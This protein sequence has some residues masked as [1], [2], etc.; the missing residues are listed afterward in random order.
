VPSNSPA[1]AAGI[2]QDDTLTRIGSEHIASPDAV[3]AALGRHR[4]GERVT[5]EYID[6]TGT[7]K[8]ANVVLGENPHVN[9]IAVEGAG[10][11]LTP[12]QRAFRDAWLRSQQ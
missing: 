1:Y 11:S 10:G 3:D 4:P 6:R 2:D 9:A 12:A 5:L 8:T 7:S